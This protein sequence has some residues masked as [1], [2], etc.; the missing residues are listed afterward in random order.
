MENSLGETI[1]AAE[2]RAR[3]DAACKA[4]LADK[5]ILA[6]ILKYCADEY[7]DCPIHK[8]MD[9]IEGQPEIGTVP[10][11]PGLANRH[12][13]KISGMATEDAVMYEGVVRYDIRF[14]TRLPQGDSYTELLVNVEAQNNFHPGES[15]GYSLVTRGIYYCA[16]MISAQKETEFAHSHYEDMKK[17]YS[18]WICLNPKSSVRGTI[19]SYQLSERNDVGDTHEAKEDYDKLQVTL[20]CLGDK[21]SNS[22]LIQML[23][24]AMSDTL[25]V[26]EKKK[27]LRKFDIETSYTLERGFSEMCNYSQGVAEK[28]LRIGMEKG[29]IEALKAMIK[30]LSLTEDQAMDVLEIPQEDRAKIKK[31]LK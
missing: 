7:K 6:W 14:R 16:R 24:V 1:S 26:D 2:E 28:N 20:V 8:I 15:P 17:V 12:A 13:E 3:L 29:H 4:I 18:I 27:Q 22:E 23:D 10:I 11:S 25:T 19:T 5:Q 31:E 21:N 9:Y 30:K